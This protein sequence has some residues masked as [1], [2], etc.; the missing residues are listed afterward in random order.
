MI[1]ISMYIIMSSILY[2]YNKSQNTQKIKYSN[3]NFAF[4]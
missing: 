2:I 4:K 1:P 3:D